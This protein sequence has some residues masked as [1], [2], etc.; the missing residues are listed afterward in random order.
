MN[1]RVLIICRAP[2]GGLFRHVHDLVLELAQRGMKVA[3]VCDNGPGDLRFQNA[4]PALEQACA[5][6]VHRLPIPRHPHPNDFF[7]LYRLVK[8]CRNL[9][10]NL[11]HGHGAKGGFY[12]R[13][14]GWWLNIPVIYTPHGGVLHY[15]KKNWDG[16]L[17]LTA[18][19]LLLPWTHTIVFESSFARNEFLRKIGKLSKNAVVVHNG[20]IEQDFLPPSGSAPAYDFVYCGELRHLKGVDVLLQAAAL[21]KAQGRPISLALYGAGPNALSF[22]K[23]ILALGLTET[24]TI[25]E[26]VRGACLA[27]QTGR[28]VIVPSRH[29]SLP[30]AVLEAAAF[31]RPF[32]A[33]HVGG[34]PEVVG[35]KDSDFLV[36]ADD[37]KA[38]ATAMVDFLDVPLP[39]EQRAIHLKERVRH[40]FSVKHMTSQLLE[41]YKSVSK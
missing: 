32:I 26:A 2:V 11:I 18:E 6:G 30:Y 1:Q 38:L 39:W 40:L 4:L 28:C 15:S 25:H 5:L 7:S 16:W 20:L 19:R 12:A 9:D 36:P 17:F 24:A 29:E 23:Q 31:G 21:I 37:A 3:L 13:P 22:E 41:V 14:L 10:I 8:L 35:S 33:T 34:I 27:Y